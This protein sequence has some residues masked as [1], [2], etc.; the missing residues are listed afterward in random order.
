MSDVNEILKS[1]REVLDPKDDNILFY[2]VPVT[3]HDNKIECLNP[4]LVS[5]QDFL[6]AKK[7]LSIIQEKLNSLYF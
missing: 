4:K 5:E 6:E 2:I 1:V 3:E 7:A